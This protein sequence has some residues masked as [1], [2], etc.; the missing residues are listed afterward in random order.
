MEW[1]RHFYTR[2]FDETL[3]NGKVPNNGH[4]VIRHLCERFPQT[5][6]VITQ[7]IDRLHRHPTS[8]VSSDQL[9]EV[10][11][12]VGAFKCFTEECKYSTDIL[13]QEKKKPQKVEKFDFPL[14]YK[15]R[16]VMTEADFQLPDCP[17][18][19]KPM[20]PNTLLFDED[21][22]D[23]KS[24]RFEEARDWLEE[25]DAVVFVGTS[26]SVSITDIALD[27]LKE[28]NEQCD[29]LV[30]NFNLTDNV[31]T[32]K[33]HLLRTMFVPGKCEDTLSHLQE[34]LQ[35]RKEVIKSEKEGG[36]DD[37]TSS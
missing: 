5:V 32:C 4:V 11:G 24:Y 15:K 23:H 28:N 33:S 14:P 7:N 31:P 26:F 22:S 21:Y 36:D 2:H 17:S 19:Q 18:C 25:S 1:Y 13:F 35:S 34:A 8:L 20:C 27:I 6:K 30:F 3:L 37:T 10:H 29:K 16:R 12:S 9:I